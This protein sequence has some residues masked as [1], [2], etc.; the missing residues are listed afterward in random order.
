MRRTVITWSAVMAL[1]LA[2]FGASVLALNADLYSAHGF[3]GRY[4]DALQRHDSAA[5]LALPGVG[6]GNDTAAELLASDAMGD[7]D[8]VRTVSDTEEADG[9]HTVVVEYTASAP[10][11]SQSTT[12]TTEFVVA[13]DGIRFGLFPSWRFVT[14]PIN[15]LSV[16][17]LHD[18]DFQVNG[19]D[20][21]SS[22]EPDAPAS[23]QVFAP[24][25]YVLK[26]ESTYLASTSVT[27]AVTQIGE[28]SDVTVDVQA[29]EAFVAEVQKHVTAYLGECTTQEVLMPTGC[30]FGQQLSNR[31]VGT[32]Q[33]SM[34]SDPLVT[35]VPGTP[36]GTWSVPKTPA[37]AHLVVDVRSLFDG[38]VTTFDEDVPFDVQ[39]ALTFE[40]GNKLLITAVY[41]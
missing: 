1:L 29:N 22:A 17:V 3:V 4:L 10:D 15:S 34:V 35:I 11:G 27:A 41:E 37:M 9:R 28:I 19:H 24:G 2:G 25:L 16:T 40:P 7:L 23:F 5:A 18:Q 31:V 12:G 20:V 6:S 30:P 33:W 38:R 21:T 36:S 14:S 8:D 39:Y 13:P 32:P 26:H